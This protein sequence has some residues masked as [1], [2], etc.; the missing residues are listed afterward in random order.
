MGGVPRKLLTGL[1]FH[2]LEDGLRT[3]H[4]EPYLQEIIEG[5]L[6]DGLDGFLMDIAQTHLWDMADSNTTAGIY[7]TVRIDDDVLKQG[8]A[9]FLFIVVSE[10]NLMCG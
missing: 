10:H 1:L 3:I 8:M 5:S 4:I 7:L 6:I 9:T 2:E